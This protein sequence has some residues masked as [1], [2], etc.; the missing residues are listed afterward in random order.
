[1]SVQIPSHW[2]SGIRQRL[3]WRQ[4]DK[5]SVTEHFSPLT[6][7]TFF[8]S[9]TVFSFLWFA[10]H[11]LDQP[12][13][14]VTKASVSCLAQSTDF[15]LTSATNKCVR[16]VVCMFL[17]VWMTLVSPLFLWRWSVLVWLIKGAPLPPL[18]PP[19]S[20]TWASSSSQQITRQVKPLKP[21]KHVQFMSHSTCV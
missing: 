20:D 7:R 15:S 10:L 11:N 16:T 13:C 18:C 14:E 6:L 12:N 3:N 5:F 4:V 2:G 17:C 21:D 8:S 9:E 1:M 19:L